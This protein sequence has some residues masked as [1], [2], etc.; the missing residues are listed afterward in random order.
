M[1]FLGKVFGEKGPKK[2][3]VSF[4]EAEYFLEK[5]LAP[6]RKKLLDDSAKKISEIKHV[7][8]QV[9]SSLKSFESAESQ[10]RT[11]RIDRIVKTAKSNALRQLSSLAE[12]LEPSNTQGLEAIKKYCSESML[13]LKQSGHFGKNVAYA[14][15]SF[16]DEMK[17]LGSHMKQLG[18]AFA[19]LN[20]LLDEGK[21]VFMQ[22]KLRNEMLDFRESALSMKQLGEKIPLLEKK[23]RELGVKE[24]RAKSDLERIVSSPEFKMVSEL[25]EK[26]ARLLREKQK[27]KTSVLNLFAKVEKPLHRLDKACKARKLFLEPD[28]A[29]FLHSLLQNPFQALKLDPKAETLKAVLFETKKAIEAGTI[30]LKEKEKE[31]KISILDELLSFDFFGETFWLFNKIDSE[32]LA[33]EKK[34]EHIPVLKKKHAFEK[35]LKQLAVEKNEA[36]KNFDL[37]K[38]ELEASKTSL[39]ARKKSIAGIL[40][41][42]TGKEVSFKA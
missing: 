33:V 12:K 3:V 24:S 8:G 10:P 19:S 21:E 27:A 7:L 25:N 42:A 30:E 16:R 29:S 36:S 15:I 4:S 26:K 40:S 23:H 32:I 38:S 18:Q 6:K 1:G 9:R 41:N 5:E 35:S 31:K 14:G 22:Q 17:I 2:V 11:G 34:L 39:E 28:K 13:A 20:R 37:A